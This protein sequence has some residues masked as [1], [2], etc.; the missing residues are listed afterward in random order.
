[1]ATCIHE[2]KATL[3]ESPVWDHRAGVLRWIDCSAPALHGW[4]PADGPLAPIALP[5]RAGS[6]ALAGRGLLTA[7][8]DGI[9]WLDPEAGALERHADPEADRPDNRF[10][11]GR[12]DRQGR[13]WVGSMHRSSRRPTGTLW[14]VGCGGEC[15]AVADGILVPNG[16]AVA[17]DG[18]RLYFADSPRGTV[19]AFDLAP[20]SGEVGGRRIF[21][22]A[23]VAPGYPDGATVDAEGYYWSARWDGGCIARIAPDGRLD[24]VFRLPVSRPTSCA[25]GGP[26][27]GTLFVT[28]ARIGI[29]A[30]ALA[31]EPLAGGL[32]ALDPGVRGL[33][34][35]VFGL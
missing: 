4:S 13:F 17:P 18:T 29:D 28:T 6:I 19:D 35:P 26:D 16:I 1:M 20:A 22:A 21:A 31:R 30:S 5:R 10:N 9:H 32:F 15:R 8:D 27:L 34:E 2:A 12:C 24:R 7:T 25:F 14:Q 23:E 11:D 33:P 3:G